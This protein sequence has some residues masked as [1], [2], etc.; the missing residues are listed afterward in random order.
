MGPHMAHLDRVTVGS[1]ARRTGRGGG[2]AGPDDV[3]DDDRLPERAGHVVGGDAG[4]DVGRPAGGERH[5]QGDRATRIV[6]LCRSRQSG[7]AD[8]E[9]GN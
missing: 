9:G 5:D 2:A 6:G 3:L 8:R 7:K 4:D 1:G